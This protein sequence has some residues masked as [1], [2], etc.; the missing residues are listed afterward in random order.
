MKKLTLIV[1]LMASVLLC[2]V[3]AEIAGPTCK[4][5]SRSPEVYT[6]Y[7]GKQ[8]VIEQLAKI[9]ANL[10]ERRVFL[11]ITQGDS[12]ADVTLYEQQENGKFTTTK[13]ALTQTS[14]LISKIDREIISTAGEKCVGAQI[15]AL[16]ENTLE[17]KPA[18]TDVTV[19]NSPKVAFANSVEHGSGKFIRTTL[20]ILC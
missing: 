18:T 20:F 2:S 14:D 16:L 10:S 12:S 1:A 17:P 3:S 5:N 4:L 19:A 9:P 13:W 15:K 6:F 8:M 7:G 11:Q